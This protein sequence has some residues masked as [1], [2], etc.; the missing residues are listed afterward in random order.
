M[1]K[2]IQPGWTPKGSHVGSSLEIV[3]FMRRLIFLVANLAGSYLRYQLQNLFAGESRRAE[4]RKLFNALAALQVREELQ[5]LKGPIM[6]LGQMLSMQSHVLPEE[7]VHE[8]T[9]LQMRAPA[10]HPA[11][12]R[13]QFKGAY[14]KFPEQVFQEFAAEPFAAASLG[15]VHRAVTKAG[16]QVAV[17]IQYPRQNFPPKSVHKT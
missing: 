13:A 4:H 5:S 6:K 8:L 15:Q 12:A 14:G 17:K 3:K 16:E 1:P 2:S 10:M 11:L 9:N 7:V